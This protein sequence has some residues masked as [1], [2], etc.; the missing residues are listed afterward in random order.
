[1]TGKIAVFPAKILSN[2]QMWFHIKLAQKILNG[3]YCWWLAQQSN[4]VEL[5]E[6]GDANPKSTVELSR[7]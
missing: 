1:M 4:I 6:N 2:M 7:N 5:Y 3:L